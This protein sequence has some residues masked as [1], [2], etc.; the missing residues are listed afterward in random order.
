MPNLFE[1]VVKGCPIV[2]SDRLLD[3]SPETACYG[4]SVGATSEM[5]GGCDHCMAMQAYYYGCDII[6]L[7]LWRFE[8]TTDEL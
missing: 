1:V 4:A 8:V 2:P 3:L 5:C 6:E 7:G